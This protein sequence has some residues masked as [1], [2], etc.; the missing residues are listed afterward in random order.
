[1]K[2]YVKINIERSDN[3]GFFQRLFG[4]KTIITTEAPNP[5][6]KE[7]RLPKF[8]EGTLGNYR[9]IISGERHI[10]TKYIIEKIQQDK[11]PVKRLEIDPHDDV[12]T[13]EYS[14]IV[15]ANNIA[16]ACTISIDF[17]RLDT[18]EEYIGK[19]F[20]I[21]G[22]RIQSNYNQQQPSSN[23]LTSEQLAVAT[24]NVNGYSQEP[25]EETQHSMTR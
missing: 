5:F 22:A 10:D 23:G 15:T 7:K 18:E 13:G 19:H 20:N 2:K 16:M 14:C 12:K 21:L 17:E 6:G 4:K 11:C 9:K 1:M 24:Q 3:M 8:H 25:S